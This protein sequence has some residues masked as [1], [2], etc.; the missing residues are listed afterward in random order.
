[1]GTIKELC[2]STGAYITIPKDHPG[3]PVQVEI[4]GGKKSVDMAVE[5]ISE[6]L[7]RRESDC[8]GDSRMKATVDARSPCSRFR[9]RP[10]SSEA[11]V[12]IDDDRSYSGR[13]ATAE[14]R[15][16]RSLMCLWLQKK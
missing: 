12:C 4:K 9:E 15:S 6:L 14:R 13:V 2:T 7:M 10:C 1:M 16:L 5:R 8:C 11:T 3:D